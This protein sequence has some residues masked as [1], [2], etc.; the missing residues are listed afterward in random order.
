MPR[1]CKLAHPPP[2]ISSLYKGGVF[3][4]ERW[5]RQG[6]FCLDEKSFFCVEKACVELLGVKRSE[7]RKLAVHHGVF[8]D[9]H[10]IRCS[11]LFGTISAIVVVTLGIAA[12]LRTYKN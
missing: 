4:L 6:G 10:M 8:P 1:P 9:G 11:V 2:K 5:A 12:P 7:N 3:G